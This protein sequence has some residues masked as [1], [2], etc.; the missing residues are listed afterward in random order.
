MIIRED[1]LD[2]T[3]PQTPILYDYR[4]Q[5]KNKSCYNTPSTYSWYLAGLVFA[6]LKRQG[7]L[8]AMAIRNQRKANKLYE[9]IDN[10]DFYSNSVHPDCRSWMNVPF[11]LQNPQLDEKF[12][13]EAE[14]DRFNQSERPSLGRRY[15]R[16]HL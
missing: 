16:Q 1:L 9:F 2:K 10:H 15:A 14:A 6:W 13:T 7:G 12:L 5:V 4:M 8:E 11:S 3:H